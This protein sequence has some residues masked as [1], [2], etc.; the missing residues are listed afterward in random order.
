MGGG[1]SVYR[2]ISSQSSLFFYVTCVHQMRLTTQNDV[3]YVCP[4]YS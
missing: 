4:Q 2:A 1:P 3:A